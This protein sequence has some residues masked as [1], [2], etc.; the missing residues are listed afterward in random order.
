MRNLRRSLVRR[1]PRTAIDRS[2]M[3]ALFGS[4]TRH[5]DAR[6]LTQSPVRCAGQERLNSLP[7]FVID[8][9]C[10]GGSSK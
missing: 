8:L 5:R 1:E 2:A 4:K 10:S 3:G 9:R 6:L 7:G